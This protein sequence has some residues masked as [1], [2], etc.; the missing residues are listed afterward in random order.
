MAKP[1]PIPTAEL[2]AAVAEAHECSQEEARRVLGSVQSAVRRLLAEGKVVRLSSLAT[3][4]VV[5]V[6]ERQVRNPATGEMQTAAP[7]RQAR[8]TATRALKVAVK[9]DVAK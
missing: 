2:V 5:D 6:P 3:F 9:E 1:K 8:V 7:T 4:S